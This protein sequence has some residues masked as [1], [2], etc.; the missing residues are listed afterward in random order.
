MN[1]ERSALDAAEGLARRPPGPGTPPGP[2][3]PDGVVLLA[4]VHVEVRVLH[5]VGDLLDVLLAQ[6]AR[7]ACCRWRRRCAALERWTNC[8]DVPHHATH[9]ERAR[10]VAWSPLR[11]TV[12][13]PFSV[14]SA[15]QVRGFSPSDAQRASVLAARRADRPVRLRGPGRRAARSTRPRTSRRRG[16][17]WRGS[18]S[19][20][21]CPPP[22]LPIFSSRSAD[23]SLPLL[24]RKGPLAWIRTGSS[25]DPLPFSCMRR[26]HLQVRAVDVRAERLVQQVL[27]VPAVARIRRRR[28]AP[29]PR[30]AADQDAEA[31]AAQ[32]TRPYRNSPPVPTL[33]K[34][35]G[36]RH[37]LI[38]IATRAPGARGARRSG[39]GRDGD[40][41]GRRPR[42]EAVRPHGP[43]AVGHRPAAPAGPVRPA[44]ARA[45]AA[46]TTRPRARRS[47]ASGR[48]AVTRA[49]K[50]A[51]RAKKIK[52]ADYRRWTQAMGQA[53]RTL[54]GLR[55]RA[56]P[57]STTCTPRSRA[58]RSA[59]G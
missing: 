3:A 9:V 50:R 5:H 31:H 51:L 23:G 26:V 21:V 49:L 25:S 24:V 11:A 48:R 34:G 14:A 47:T 6:L 12:S 45:S 58:S 28:P 55:A 19:A 56:G 17:R 33:E 53:R 57:S 32:G 27:D 59:G 43:A 2:R 1:V 22:S 54:R 42:R 16:R 4:H 46:A 15:S 52:R 10:H 38:V 8:V 20:M 39:P 35:C 13:S 29:A 41:G 36:L 37:R 30:R 44:T 7:R 18:R 40:R